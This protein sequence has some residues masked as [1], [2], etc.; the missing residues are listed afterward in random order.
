MEWISNSRP[1]WV[2]LFYKFCICCLPL[3]LLLLLLFLLLLLLFHLY[4]LS[5]F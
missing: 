5:I 3:L 4:C 1:L 2:S